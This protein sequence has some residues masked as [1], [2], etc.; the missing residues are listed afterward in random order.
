MASALNRCAAKGYR[1]MKG[2]LQNAIVVAAFG[3]AFLA[4]EAAYSQ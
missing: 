1:G 4:A 3:T 2:L